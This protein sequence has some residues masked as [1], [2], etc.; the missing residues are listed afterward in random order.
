MR[1]MEVVLLRNIKDLNRQDAE[2]ANLSHVLM[3]RC[4]VPKEVLIRKLSHLFQVKERGNFD[5][6]ADGD[7]R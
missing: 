7:V 3:E 4:I 6:D 5:C 2:C 1:L